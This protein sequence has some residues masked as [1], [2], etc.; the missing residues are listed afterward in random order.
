MTQT[1]AGAELTSYV[2]YGIRSPRLH[3][4]VMMG[5]ASGAPVYYARPARC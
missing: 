3:A 2:V 5:V 4:A 1:D